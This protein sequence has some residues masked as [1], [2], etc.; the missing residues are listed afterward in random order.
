M[1]ATGRPSDASRHKAT[2]IV[3]DYL[4]STAYIWEL[5]EAAEIY[6]ETKRTGDKLADDIARAIDEAAA[7]QRE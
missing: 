1:T 2:L 6:R 4:A 3:A 5:I 7:E